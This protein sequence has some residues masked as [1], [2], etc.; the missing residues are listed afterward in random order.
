MSRRR[1]VTAQEL[2]DELGVTLADVLTR[3][4]SGAV[5]LMAPPRAETVAA[6]ERGGGLDLLGQYVP[7]GIMDWLT[8]YFAMSRLVEDPQYAKD[9][10]LPYLSNG[11]VYVRANVIAERIRG[12]FYPNPTY[13]RVVDELRKINAQRGIALGSSYDQASSR[14]IWWRLPPAVQQKVM[15]Q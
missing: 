14:L 9:H 7:N 4:E 12:Q 11:R 10:G 8:A 13:K 2:A 1:F 15:P 6:R 5:R 3:V